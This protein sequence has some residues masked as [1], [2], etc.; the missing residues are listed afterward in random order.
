MGSFTHISK[1]ISPVRIYLQV[2]ENLQTSIAISDFWKHRMYWR[3]YI[4]SQIPGGFANGNARPNQQY[5][6]GYGPCLH[7]KSF[8]VY[9]SLTATLD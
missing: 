7:Y 6:G 2:V 3:T 1:N 9:F 4:E 8:A 5:A